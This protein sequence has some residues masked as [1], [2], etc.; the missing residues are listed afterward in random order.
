[1]RID[2]SHIGGYIVM[3]Q[4]VKLR[5]RD[6]FFSP[7]TVRWPDTGYDLYAF[8]VFK[9][10]YYRQD[11][12]NSVDYKVTLTP[13]ENFELCMDKWDM[14][15]SDL[16]SIHKGLQ[17]AENFDFSIDLGRNDTVYLYF[18]KNDIYKAIIT[19]NKLNYKK[20]KD[21]KEL[22]AKNAEDTF[23]ILKKVLD[24]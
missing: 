16:C 24:F 9:I 18:S 8:G 3:P 15:T 7:F 1:M 4:K 19:A 11:P 5:L 14:Y 20:F 13:I 23:N 10:D 12:R 17:P 6:L 21:L 2:T 22:S